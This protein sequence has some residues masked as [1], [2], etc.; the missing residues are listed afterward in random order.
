MA[1]K[2]DATGSIPAITL[3]HVQY[4]Q[5]HVSVSREPP[6][7][8]AI[9]AEVQ[10]YG[11]DADGVRYYKHKPEAP[12]LID[13]MDAFIAALPSADQA[14]AMQAMADVQRGLGVL[15]Q[16]KTGVNFVAVD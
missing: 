1:I 8:T 9:S 15:Y 3:D 13:D 2:T 10:L 12:L 4:N 5:L 16:L 11:R 14:E 7:R 6:Y